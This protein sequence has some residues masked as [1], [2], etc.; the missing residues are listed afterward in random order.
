M[1]ISSTHLL[2][3][4]SILEKMGTELNFSC[5]GFAGAEAELLKRLQSVSHEKMV[6]RKLEVDR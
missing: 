5:T 3:L 4:K 1:V 2:V 6:L